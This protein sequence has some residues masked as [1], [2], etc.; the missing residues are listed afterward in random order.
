MWF[1]LCKKGKETKATVKQN[2]IFIHTETDRKNHVVYTP[3][4]HQA[5]LLA[6]LKPW[7]RDEFFY[8]K[9]ASV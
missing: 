4:E 9:N 1:R 6:E 5:S 2:Y 3:N 7:R 8:D